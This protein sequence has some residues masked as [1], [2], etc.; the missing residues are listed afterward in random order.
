M[1]TMSAFAKGEAHRDDPMMV[2]DW[3]KAA[4][5]I[6]ERGAQSASA[7]LAGDWE[8]T[9]GDI[10]TDGKP[11][12]EDYTYLS[13]TWATPQ[14]NIDGDVIDCWVYQDDKPEWDCDTKWPESAVEIL[15]G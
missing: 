5:I 1:D 6:K 3:D 4:Q 15:N 7:G 10:L 12:M 2:F 9:G 8:Y 13:S 11:N 14:L